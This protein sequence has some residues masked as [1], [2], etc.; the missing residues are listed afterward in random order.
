MI[1]GIGVGSQATS[2]VNTLR[3]WKRSI[4]LVSGAVRTYGS[5]TAESFGATPG[6]VLDTSFV[7]PLSSTDEVYV[8]FGARANSA[9][10]RTARHHVGTL[11]P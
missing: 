4:W 6:G 9:E 10:V 8:G 1:V 3:I 11:T 5:I 2:N 7:I